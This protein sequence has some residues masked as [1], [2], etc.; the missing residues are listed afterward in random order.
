MW[1]VG[2]YVVLVG[3]YVV[4]VGE[5]GVVSRGAQCG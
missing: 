1:L 4:L 5:Y 3:E 2:E